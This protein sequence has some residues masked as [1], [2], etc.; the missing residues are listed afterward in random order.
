MERRKTTCIVKLESKEKPIYVKLKN[1]GDTQMNA[2]YRLDVKDSF[3]VIV[4][5]F[6]ILAYIERMAASS[7]VAENKMKNK[8]NKNTYQKRS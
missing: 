1:K 7:L 8:R 3:H 2:I 6:Y 4:F 5:C